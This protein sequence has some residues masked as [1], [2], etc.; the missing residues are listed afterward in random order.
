MKAERRHK[1]Q[2]SDLAKVITK[3]PTFWQESGGKLLAGVIIVL[4]I[5][6]LF[7][8]RMRTKRQGIQ[9]ASQEISTARRI[10]EEIQQLAVLAG[11]PTQEM[12]TRRRVYFND[13]NDA[14]TRAMQVTDD[15]K[16]QAEALLAKGD[17]NWS[18]AML[19]AIP[20]ASTQ[21][22]L[23]VKDPKDLLANAAEAY[24]AVLDN[25]PDQKYAVIAARFGMAAINENRG[26]WDAAK[27][28]YEKAALDAKNFPAYQSL[29]SIKLTTLN[30]LK[31]PVITGKPSTMPDIPP[32]GTPATQAVPEILRPNAA[33]TM[34]AG[35]TAPATTQ[36]HP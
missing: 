24:K 36:A 21:P 14:L 33:T 12:A 25:Y 15:P 17:I 34:A 3:A 23:G 32:A 30:E 2:Q 9:Q 1:L 16:L 20:G 35:A 18:L 10:N 5:V 26:E 31:A 7:Q 27:A 11:A 6:I 8:Y 13:A 28:Q 19:P 22:S 4:V 29:A